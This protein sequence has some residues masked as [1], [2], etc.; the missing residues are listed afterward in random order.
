MGHDKIVLADTIDWPFLSEKMAAVYTDGP[1]QLPLSTRLM[2]ELHILKYTDDLSDDDVCAWWL[3]K[4][5]YKFYCNEKF[6]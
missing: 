4:H 1:G 5:Y 3:E 6:S 2:A